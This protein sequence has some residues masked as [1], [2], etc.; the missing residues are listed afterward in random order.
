MSFEIQIGVT[1]SPR[2]KIDKK[3]TVKYTLQGTLRSSCSVMNPSIDIRIGESANIMIPGLTKCNYAYI[4]NFNRYYYITDF[5]VI[6]NT[7]GNFTCHVDVLKTFAS[8]IK[9]NSALIRR[10]SSKKYYT[11]MIDDG[12]FK[13]YANPHIVVKKFTG[14]T[15]ASKGEFVLAVS[16]SASTSSTS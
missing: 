1:N 3:F 4:P 7:M 9:S 16:G 11:K 6:R 10:A 13:A 8:E 14:D 5:Q 2:N 15:F 12:C